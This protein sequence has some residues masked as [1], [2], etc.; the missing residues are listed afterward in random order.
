MSNFN[1][2]NSMVSVL[3][4]ML[5]VAA[6]SK[7]SAQPPAVQFVDWTDIVG[8][9]WGAIESA[10]PWDYSSTWN[11]N[12]GSNNGS[13][14]WNQS[15][16]VVPNKI[17]SGFGPGYSNGASGSGKPITVVNPQQNGGNVHF[18]M[19]TSVRTRN[20]GTDYELESGF[21]QVLSDAKRVITFHRGVTA[22]GRSLGT[23]SYTLTGGRA[24]Q[25]KVTAQGWDL[26]QMKD[27]T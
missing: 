4:T 9:V 25:F 24:Y 10:D 16:S 2:R 17:P 20:R 5:V 11:G 6:T 22:D 3:A 19:S 18:R 26:A 1:L 13:S 23:K 15:N 12:Y 8:D 27:P 7:A 21:Q 14:G